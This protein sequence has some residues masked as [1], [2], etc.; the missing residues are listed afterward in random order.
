M[1]ALPALDF[2]AED[3]SEPLAARLV[4][5]LLTAT[6][7]A[8]AAVPEGAEGAD[9][10]EER[11]VWATASRTRGWPRRS[12]CGTRLPAARRGVRGPGGGGEI[13]MAA[14]AGGA[15][16]AV[17]AAARA[18]MVGPAVTGEIVSGG[19]ADPDTRLNAAKCLD[20]FACGFCGR[21]GKSE[22]PLASAAA[23][24]LLPWLPWLECDLDD[25][26]VGPAASAAAA[27]AVRRGA[28]AWTPLE[29][30]SADFFTIPRGDGR[31]GDGTRAPWVRTSSPTEPPGRRTW[32]LQLTG[33][34]ATR[35][36]PRLLLRPKLSDGA[37]RPFGSVVRHAD[38]KF[39]VDY[40]E[41]R[42]SPLAASVFGGTDV[43]NLVEVMMTDTLGTS[44]RVV[45]G[46]QLS[47]C[48]ADPSLHKVVCSREVLARLA[49][50]SATALAPEAER[51]TNDVGVAALKVLAT[52]VRHSREARVFFSEVARA[53][54]VD[55]EQPYGRSSPVLPLVFH[56]RAAVRE[57][58]AVF[59]AYVVFGKVA[60]LA[61]THAGLGLVPD[62]TAM[63][64]PAS[65]ARQLRFPVPIRPMDAAALNRAR[66]AA[67]RASSPL[68]AEG[69]D[70]AR[71]RAMLAQRREVRRL[72]GAAGVLATV[73]R[74]LHE[75]GG[76]ARTMGPV[77]RVADAT[78]RWAS[79]ASSAMVSLAR[80]AHARSHDDATAACASS[81]ASSPLD[82]PAPAPSPPRHGRNTARLLHPAA[83]A[84]GRR[85]WASLASPSRGR[86]RRDRPA[87]RPPPWLAGRSAR[88]GA[89]HPRGAVGATSGSR[90]DSSLRRRRFEPTRNPSFP[91]S[92]TP[93][94]TPRSAGRWP[95][96][97]RP[98]PRLPASSPR[99]SST[100]P[101]R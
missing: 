58:L 48:A 15:A 82:R 5:T 23:R 91:P 46:D 7:S 80:L 20:A 71:V 79:P 51:V 74:M 60:D 3:E 78:L 70:R 25:D 24:A 61:T 77:A 86:A 64:V 21:A 67:S 39:A 38:N 2:I 47:L 84:R 30:S 76:D 94:P 32:M 81:A 93:L 53:S 57:H 97:R 18:V 40:G 35:R 37:G 49:G 10:F 12:S 83:V 54:P 19:L 63:H 50:L 22:S 45:A 75:A 27:A 62:P 34:R 36:A 73:E 66:L 13:A 90:R 33:R 72:G 26:V 41:V 68:E 6:A 9:V 29:P 11:S 55:V 85:L 28:D 69:T 87:A 88:G 99:V 52:C 59:C 4:A 100:P 56:P 14:E 16:A 42:A 44:V 43:G 95:R 31:G 92:P 1:E 65:I 101:W 89:R 17:S 98:P 96:R 8:T